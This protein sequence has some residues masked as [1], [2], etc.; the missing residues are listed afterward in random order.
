[1]TDLK[2]LA[3]EHLAKAKSDK[4]GRSAHLFLHD[5]PL[6]QAVIALSEGARL[7][8]HAAPPAASLQVLAG[9]VRITADGGDIEVGE[10]GVTRIPH[11]RHGVTALSDAV[12][13][14]T[15]VTGVELP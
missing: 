9:R 14:L 13:V 3:D 5:G 8:E 7:E 10:G 11:E 15:T 6:R 12:V 1:M 4:N 2:A